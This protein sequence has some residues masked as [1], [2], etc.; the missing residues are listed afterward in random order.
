MGTKHMKLTN[1]Q[2]QQV[3]KA[4]SKKWNIS[5]GFIERLFAKGLARNVDDAFLRLQ[6]KAE[7]RKKQGK[8]VPKSWQTFLDAKK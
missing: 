8:P 4:I 5:E 3:K 7:E 2:K 1:E 6:K